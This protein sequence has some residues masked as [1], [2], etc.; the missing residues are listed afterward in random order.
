MAAVAFAAPPAREALVREAKRRFQRANVLYQDGR[1]ADALHLY[2]AAYDLV[3]SPDI[4]FNIG[5]S[6]EKIFDY[7]GCSLTFRQYLEQAH[8]DPRA[9]QAR[10]RRERC[11]AQTVIDVKV[12]SLPAA[13]AVYLGEGETRSPRGRTPAHLEL[14]PGSYF[15]TVEAPGYVPQTQQI[16]VEEGLH[17]DIDF[18]LEK[19]STLHIE[20]DVGG[21]EVE[22]DGHVVGVTPCSRELRAGLYTILVR[23]AG[24][25]PVTRDVRIN[26]GD[27]VSLVMAL[28]ALPRE[29]QLAVELS[30]PVPAMVQL[31]GAPLGPAPLE[32]KVSAGTHSI[33]LS[34]AGFVPYR[35]ELPMGDDGDVRLR[36]HLTPRRSRAQRLFFWT[37]QSLATSAATLGVVFGALALRDQSRFDA[38]PSVALRDEGRRWALGSDL[39]FIASAA[40]GLAA[41]VYYLVTWPRR[42]RAERLPQ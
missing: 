3:P 39:S 33:E 5:L 12:S 14:R 40:I 24:Y 6:K 29:R 8:D 7:E 11:R 21:A 22:L 26:P 9:V 32:K 10:E 38:Q 16:A 4:L 15:I 17:P 19:L 31:D 36:V 42:S 18:T 35:G 20:A 37:A 25:K 30:P 34:S 2:Q 28:P 41:G 27:Q 23:K 13:A 1:Y